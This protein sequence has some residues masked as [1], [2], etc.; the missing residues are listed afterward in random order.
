MLLCIAR[1]SWVAF[2]IYVLLIIVYLLM[3][4]KKNY[5]KRVLTIAVIFLICLTC[6]NML[7]KN[8]T[9]SN[10]VNKMQSEIKTIT[11]TQEMTDKMGSG[12]IE[13]WKLTARLIYKKPILGAGVDAIEDG[14]VYECT[15]EYLKILEKHPI[16]IDKAHNEYLQIAATMGIPALCT[17]LIFLGTILTPSIDYFRKYRTIATLMIVIISYLSQAFFNISTIGIAPIFWFIL[18]IASRNLKYA[19]NKEN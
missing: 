9:V 3:K 15:D 2:A 7:D 13:I 18:G 6:V 16:H 10:K 14:Y 8:K 19:R 12:R 4:R 11:T 5:F 17:Y 1:S